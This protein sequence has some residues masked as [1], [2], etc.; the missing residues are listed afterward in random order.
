MVASAIPTKV[1][2]AFSRYDIRTSKRLSAGNLILIRWRGELIKLLLSEYYHGV[3]TQLELATIVIP[4]FGHVKR[5][6]YYILDLPRAI[7]NSLG[8]LCSSI[9]DWLTFCVTCHASDAVSNIHFVGDTSL[10]PTRP[11]TSISRS[12]RF[13]LMKT[14]SISH[15]VSKCLLG[16]HYSSPLN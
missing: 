14:Y 2:L 4:I 9:A 10:K 8:F 5:D 15:W 7:I 3:I 11:S 13:A 6:I 1:R 12:K 16:S